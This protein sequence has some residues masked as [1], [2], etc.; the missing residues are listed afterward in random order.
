MRLGDVPVFVPLP[1]G[2]AAASTSRG[3][4]PL[5]GAIQSVRKEGSSFLLLVRPEATSNSSLLATSSDALC[6]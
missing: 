2:L 3:A 1:G 6:Y 5:G 4:G